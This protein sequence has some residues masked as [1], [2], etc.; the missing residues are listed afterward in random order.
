MV[1]CMELQLEKITRGADGFTVTHTRA[2]QRSDKTS[3]KFL[4]PQVGGYADQL[5]NYLEKVKNNQLDAFTGKVWYT[6]QKTSPALTKMSMG[7]NTM[8]KIPHEVAA[9]LKLSNPSIYTFH[10]FRRTSATRAADAGATSEQLVDFFG[11]KNSSMC[12]EYISS[13]KPAVLGM[14]NRLSGVETEKIP[15]KA[16][17]CSIA[18]F[19]FEEDE[20]ML[21]AAG[22]PCP[23]KTVNVDQKT[24]Q[25]GIVEASIQ[26][27]LSA[28]PAAQQANVNLKIV[29]VNN[30]SASINM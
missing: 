21:K 1:E 3:T 23:Q 9:L 4:V 12:Q 24:G 7:K 18:E 6:G 11:W 29:V 16:E 27:T 15:S 30:M 26:K 22:I 13:S 19:V 14:A 8:S 2:K 28:F 20:E 25:V 10:S 5:A 17:E